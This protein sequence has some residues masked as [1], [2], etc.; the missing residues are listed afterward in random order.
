MRASLALA[1]GATALAVTAGLT[2]L[3][4]GTAAAASGAGPAKPAPV[5]KPTS[6]DTRAVPLSSISPAL[7]QQ[8]AAAHLSLGA[9]AAPA[10]YVYIVQMRSQMYSSSCVDANN[11][12]P[13]AGNDRDIVQLWHCYNDSVNHPNQWWIPVQSLSGYTELANYQYQGEC[14][15]ADSSHGFQNGSQVQLWHCINNETTNSNQWWD[16]GPYESGYSV[17]PVDWNNNYRYLDVN[18]AGPSA[19]AD[20][21]KIQIWTPDN[22]SSPNQDF[23]Q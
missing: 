20:G 17:L 12:G 1:A 19:G 14:L 16:Y 15:D 7:R 5:A 18:D 6:G 2:A 8:A 22:P 13:S 11:Y 10:G 21:D 23:D 4:A 9:K 3:S